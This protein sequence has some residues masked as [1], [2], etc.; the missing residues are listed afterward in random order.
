[1]ADTA[2]LSKADVKPEEVPAYLPTN[3][4]RKAEQDVYGD[5]I[6]AQIIL[7]KKYA[8]FNDRNL[9][10]AIDDWT[11]R[12]NGYVPPADALLDDDQSRMFL[13]FTRNQIINFL[14]RAA[15][16]RPKAHLKAVNKK[17]GM[18]DKLL[19]ETLEDLNEYSLD[20]EN[21]EARF[22]EAALECITKGTVV[23]YEG[24]RKE[25]QKIDIPVDVD[26]ETGKVKTEQ[27]ERVVYDDCFQEVV[28]LEDFFIANPYEPDVQK[29]PFVIR[30]KV[31][32][33]D[34]AA[35]TFQKY[36]NWKYV[37]PGAYTMATEP[38]TFYRNDVTTQL[39][40]DQ[41]EIL[42][43]YKKKENKLR[44]LCS[45]IILYDG[46]NPFKD[47][48]YPFAKGIFEP[49][50][51]NFFWGMGFPQKIMGE[52]DMMNTFWNMAADKTYGSLLPYGL[53]SDLDD[54]IE[55]DLLRPN[56][57]RKVSDINK[58]K[59]DSLPGV[60]P[61]EQSMIQLAVQ[62]AR[63]NS[64]QGTG[65]SPSGG[66]ISARQAMMQQQQALMQ[67]SL[68]LAYLED[69][70]V[71]RT[72]LRISHILQF[73]AIPKI[74]KIT[75]TK[76]SQLEKML[77]RDVRLDGTKLRSGKQGSRVIKLVNGV[78]N[79]DEKKKLQDDMSVL[80][81][82]AELQGQHLEVL[83]LDISTFND[84]DMGVS[85]VRNSS[86]EKNET[87]DQAVRRE[88]FQFRVEAAQLG[89]PCNMPELVNWV[90]ESF[91]VDASR[92]EGQP[93]APTGMQPPQPGQGPGGNT[94]APGKAQDRTRK[95]AQPVANA[96]PTRSKMGSLEGV[97]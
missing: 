40:K 86:Y 37:K 83:A 25:K 3:D 79:A 9:D 41:V 55:D 29:Q 73:Y 4:E 31:T 90:S 62:F 47:G 5:F 22:L 23:V 32:A 26:M 34:T 96:N 66:K 17:S 1:M 57:I 69:F 76:G 33:Y 46:P 7:N 63:E 19:S 80:E 67:S 54:I 85:V 60:T 12:W 64:G 28:P 13:N 10:D 16:S 49:F 68:S 75:S 27:Q 38:T 24:Y 72:K 89:V 91:D 8:Q 88:Y 11:K 71:D 78:K 84:F 82:K 93:G 56:K 52:Q 50:E 51:V 42:W 65:A 18:P 15:L 36:K 94:Q 43:E 53:S 95:R 97:L 74:E 48:N 77:Y 2:S 6:S 21:G 39:S 45:G 61:G 81:A 30:R 58:W 59:F 92:F 87:L 44:I 14:A 70:E 20:Q 35:R